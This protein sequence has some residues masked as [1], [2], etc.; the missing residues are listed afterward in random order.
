MN[1]DAATFWTGIACLVLGWVAFW[2]LV[3]RPDRKNRAIVHAAEVKRL[4]TQ[5]ASAEADA[6]VYL[7][8]VGQIAVERTAAVIRADNYRADLAQQQRACDVHLTSID[9][10]GWLPTIEG[11][12]ADVLDSVAHLPV[13]S[14]Y[15][16]LIDAE[17]K[18]VIN[19]PLLKFDNGADVLPIRGKS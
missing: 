2:L 10:R 14:V 5:L 8:K 3:H 7:R 13:G 15:D 17:F 11:N 4:R 9:R 19:G 12:R 1:P 6:E 18:A 16:A